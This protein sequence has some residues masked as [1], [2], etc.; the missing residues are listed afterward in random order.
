MTTEDRQHIE[1]VLRKYAHVFHDEESND[2]NENN[3]IDHRII[4]GDSNQIR[5]PP[6]RTPYALRED[7]QSQVQNMLNKGIIRPSSSPWSATAILVPTKS[8]DD[9]PNFG[10]CVDFRALNTVTQ[11]DPYSLPVFEETTSTLHGYKH[12]TVLD[13]Y[14]DLWQVGITE[15]HKGRTGFS[16]ASGHYEFNRLPFGLSN[17]TTN[18]KLI[19]A[20]LKDLVGTECWVFIDIIVCSKSA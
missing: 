2:I 16:V 6:Y 17:S 18:F 10:F 3:V 4:A 7:M 11:F 15:E 19:E 1:P 13:S 12:F 5:R 9:K 14:S 20:V 8:Q